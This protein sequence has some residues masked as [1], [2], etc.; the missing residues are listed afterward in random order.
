MKLFLENRL[1]ELE[2]LTEA[3]ETLAGELD[4]PHRMVF[5]VNL[6]LEEIFT[7]IV[8]HGCKECE[9]HQIECVMD[10]I[11]RTLTITLKDK[12]LPF[13]PTKAPDPDLKCPVEDRPIGKLGIFLVKKFMDSM[14]YRREADCNIITL[15]KQI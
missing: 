5:E 3:F 9:A 15:T 1:G 13:D 7:N 4:I 8:S 14:E 12:G 6:A 2:R 10:C 11:N